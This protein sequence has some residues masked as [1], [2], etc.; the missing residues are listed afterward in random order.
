M[1]VLPASRRIG[2]LLS[3]RGSNFRAIA[4]HVASGALD[5]EIALVLSNRETAPG[6]GDARRRGLD[7]VCIPSA[8]LA[9]EA[10]DEAVAARLGA[11]GVSLVCL[12]GFM[13]ILGSGLVRSFPYGILNIHPSLLPAFPGLDPQ[14]QALDHGVRFSGCTVHFVDESLDGG[15]IVE[16][17]VVPVLP[18]DSAEELSGRILVEEHRI[19]SEAIGA[20]LDGRCEVRGRRV[21]IHEAGT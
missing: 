5:A 9:R 10:F 3:G 2:I 20:V 17:A 19:Y 8:G 15:P 4:D 18:E 1:R 16:Q 12:A 13:R 6:L 7:A 11:H 14:R 21:V